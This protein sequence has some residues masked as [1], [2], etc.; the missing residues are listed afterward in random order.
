MAQ[1][2]LQ[3]CDEFIELRREKVSFE[4][5]RV[6]G[7]FATIGRYSVLVLIYCQN[8][9]GRKRR[10][11]GSD[12]ERANGFRKVQRL[13]QLAQKFKH[14]I[15]V[16]CASSTSSTGTVIA[17]SHESL[18]FPR[19]ILS[20]WYLE[21]PIILAVLGRRSSGDIFGTWLADKILALEQ[22]QFVVNI[23][24]QGKNSCRHVGASKLLRDGIIDKTILVP[25]N[26]GPHSQAVM[27]YRLRS[28]LI[29][30]LDDVFYLS[31]R[32]LIIRRRAKIALVEAFATKLSSQGN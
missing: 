9:I 27:P 15:V 24:D 6:I 8:G 13:M 29:Q 28:A 17:E 14:P 10:V 31:S 5:N 11:Q 19:H 23:S 3:A 26:R 7:G 20:Q 4:K 12:R 22:T 30:M 16:C 1:F 2:I 21:A 18:G 25:L 32:E